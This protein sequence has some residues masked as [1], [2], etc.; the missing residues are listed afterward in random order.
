MILG[1]P[2]GQYVA[3]ALQIPTESIELG[4]GVSLTATSGSSNKEL[5]RQSNLALLQLYA[6]LG[7]QF[8]Q[9]AQIAQGAASTPLGEVATQLFNGGRELMLRVMEQFDVRNPEELIPNVS[10]LLSAQTQ[11][12]AGSAVSPL[13]NQAGGNAVGGFL[14]Q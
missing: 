12:G 11:M 1:M 13:A 5:Q 4:I 2:E 14:P 6:Q 10:A 9:L 3:Q 8:L 7:P